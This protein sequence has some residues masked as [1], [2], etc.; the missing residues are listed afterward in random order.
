MA[1]TKLPFA[2][3]VT[4]MRAAREGG[5]E[6]EGEIKKKKNK[7]NGVKRKWNWRG[8]IKKV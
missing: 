6:S 7:W 5:K 2:K 8:E 1:S 4:P 3:G